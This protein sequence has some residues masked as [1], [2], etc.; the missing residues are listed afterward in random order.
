MKTGFITLGC[1]CLIVSVSSGKTL[2]SGSITEDTTW[3][4]AGS[5]YEV[6]NASVAADVTLTIQPGAVVQFLDWTSLTIHGRILANG[7]AA[8][9]I[10]FT[11]LSGAT[12]GN[13]WGAIRLTNGDGGGG[14]LASAFSHC[15]FEGGG[16]WF[17]TLL[18][19]WGGAQVSVSDCAFRHSNAD[20]IRFFEDAGGPIE[21]T[22]FED[23]DGY[24]LW[25]RGSSPLVHGCRFTRN[26]NIS[27]LESG[28]GKGSFPN[29]TQPTF[30]DSGYVHI[31][32]NID[33]SGTLTAAPYFVDGHRYALEGQTITIDG[34]AS[35]AMADWASWTIHGNLIANGT[36]AAPIRF[37]RAG[38]NEWGAI[39]LSNND[40]NGDGLASHLTHCHFEGGGYWFQT[41]LQV[42]GGSPATLDHCQFHHSTLDGLRFF[43]NSGTTITNSLFEDNGRYGLWLRGSSPDVQGSTFTGNAY[44]SRLESGAGSG[45][46]PQFADTH[47]DDGQRVH[48]ASNFDSGGTL[49]AAP[50]FLD[51]HRYALEDQTITIDAGASFA[52]ADWASWTIHGNLIANGTEAAPIRFYRAGD[53]EWGA[54]ILSN[55]D[56]NGERRASH[57]THCHFDGGGYWFQTLLQVHGEAPATIEDCQFRNSTLDGLR[58]FEN[59]GGPIKRSTFSDN[60]SHGLWL[61]GS[62]PLV[63]ACQFTGNG[64]A[65]RLESGAGKSSLPIFVSSTFAPGQRVH[66]ATNMPTSGTFT[67]APYFLDGHRVCESTESVTIDAGATFAMAAWSTW[68]I[69]G[70][71][72]AEGT[73]EAPITFSRAGENEW[74]AVRLTNH[75][76]NGPGL[77]NRLTYCQFSG[78][79]YWYQTLL[80]A[81]G[82]APITLDHCHFN[83]ST[84]DLARLSNAPESRLDHC[85]FENAAHYGLRLQSASPAIANSTFQSCGH[86]GILLL[87]SADHGASLPTFSNNVFGEDDYIEIGNN[88]DSSG[89]LA[90]PGQAYLVNGTRT[91]V[92]GADLS[93]APGTTIKFT[94]WHSLVVDGSL[95]ALGTTQRP[96]TFTSDDEEKEGH[97]WGAVVLTGNRT[98]PSAFKHCLLEAGGYWYNA[99]LDLSGSSPVTV[100]QCQLAISSGA[101]I[102]T[103]GGNVDIMLSSISAC[104]SHGIQVDGSAPRI[105]ACDLFENAQDGIHTNN[106]NATV[107]DCFLRDNARAGVWAASGTPPRVTNAF[108]SGNGEWGI[109]NRGNSELM[110]INN[111]WGDATGPQ[112]ATLNPEGKGD[113][114]SDHVVFQ[115]YRVFASGLPQELEAVLHNGE[116]VAGSFPRGVNGFYYAVDVPA[117]QNLTLSLD[118]ANDEGVTQ[119]YMSRGRYPTPGH[120]Q[121]RHE[122]NA[123]DQRLFA[124][125]A[126]PGR[127]YVLVYQFTGE[128]SSAY[129]IRADLADIAIQ[130]ISPE[131]HSNRVGFTMQIDGAGFTAGTHVALVDG[132]RHVNALSVDVDAFTRVTAT[133][134]SAILSGRY[135]VE[136]SVPGKTPALLPDAFE[137]IDGGHPKLVTDLIVPAAVGYHQL[138][139]LYVEYANEGDVAMP[140]PLLIVTGFQNDQRRALLTLEKTRLVTGFWTS[141]IPEGFA[142][143][144]QILGSGETPGILQPGES[145]RIPVY[146]AGWQKPWDFSYPPIEFGLSTLEAT[147][148]RAIDWPTLKASLNMGVMEPAAFEIIWQ[149]YQAGIG[150]T[151]GEFVTMLGQNAAYLSRLGHQIQD[152]S[153]L[154][155]FEFLQAEGMA[156]LPFLDREVDYRL[157]GAG[158]PLVFERLFPANLS[159]RFRQGDFG[160]GWWHSWD[161]RSRTLE[162]GTV[163]IAFQGQHRVFQPD[164]RGGF[165]AAPHDSGRLLS[166][167]ADID[168]RLVEADGKTYHFSNGQFS[169]VEDRHGNRITA[170][171]TG[172]RLSKLQHSSGASL[173]LSYDGS[174]RL[175]AITDHHQRRTSYAYTGEMLSQVTHANGKQSNY[176]YANSQAGAKAYALTAIQRSDKSGRNYN[177]D[178]NGRVASTSREGG[179][180]AVAITYDGHGSAHLTDALGSTT[181]VHFDHHGLATKTTDGHGASRIQRMSDDLQFEAE[182]DGLGAMRSYAYDSSGRLTSVTG[183]LGGERT[184]TYDRE[185]R[186]TAF[187]DEEGR[188]TSAAYDAQGNLIGVTYADG[189]SHAY[190]YDAQGNLS[191]FV[192]GRGERVTLTHDQAGRLTSKTYPDGTSA[193]YEYDARGRLSATDGTAGRTEYAYNAQDLPTRVTYPQGTSLTYQYDA[194]GRRTSMTNQRGEVTRYAYDEAGRIARLSDENG[195]TLVAYDYNAAGKIAQQTLPDGSAVAYDYHASGQVSE[196]RRYNASGTL[197][198]QGTITYDANSH[199]AVIETSQG[200]RRFEW[201]AHGQVL[202]QSF[203]PTGGATQT[204][205]YDYDASGRLSQTSVDGTAQP[206]STDARGNYLSAGNMTYEHD[207]DGNVTKVTTPSGSIDYTYDSENRLTNASGPDFIWTRTIDP[208]GLTTAIEEDAQTYGV[209]ND[210]SSPVT[211]TGLLTEAGETTTNAL[212]G[213]GFLSFQDP[214]SNSPLTQPNLISNW[215]HDSFPLTPLGLPLVLHVDDV[216]ALADQALRH[217][218]THQAFHNPVTDVLTHS[219]TGLGVGGTGLGM[220]FYEIAKGTDYVS[221]L[222]WFG[223]ANTALTGLSYLAGTIET[224]QGYQENDGYKMSHGIG[225]IGATALGG[226][227]TSAGGVAILGTAALPVSVGLGAAVLILDYG[228]RDGGWM[229]DFW[230]WWDDLDVKGDRIKTK[231][232]QSKDPNEKYGPAGQGDA[233]Y[234]SPSKTLSY[235]VD[236]EN[237]HDARAPAQVVMISDPLSDKLDWNSFELTEA[238]FGDHVI[239]VPG[240]S[241]SLQWVEPMTY[242]G[243]DLEV[244]ID[245]N[246]DPLTG[247]ITAIFSSTDAET[248]LPPEVQYGFLPP[249]DETGRGQGYFSYLIHAKADLPTGTEIRN[250]ATITFDFGEVIDTNQVDPHDP[251]QG[252]DPEKEAL[253]TIDG[254]APSS[255]VAS[256]PSTSSE[257]F[258]VSWSGTDVGAGVGSY[259]IYVRQG[260]GAF[261]PWLVNTQESS[262]P[263]TGINGRTYSFYAIARD[264]VGNEEAL[265]ASSEATTTID[266]GGGDAY[267]DWLSAHFTPAEIN[268][269]VIT[270]RLADPDSDGRTNLEEFAFA[271]DPRAN[272]VAEFPISRLGAHTVF[273]YWRQRAGVTY[274]VETS[275]NLQDWALTTPDAEEVLETEGTRERVRVIMPFQP[276]RSRYLRVLADG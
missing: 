203:T 224:V 46:F 18:E 118:D 43:E 134:P 234:V 87:S 4:A 213:N 273:E 266:G 258:L 276:D 212:F 36:E 208:T 217:P 74:G 193:S 140:A 116:A 124:P 157:Q 257:T 178:S 222:K 162:D 6:N 16:Y 129:T 91:I 125:T 275:A 105:D 182:E 127:W 35:F 147:D 28:G 49:T 228:A 66:I 21:A 233:H 230:I 180:E 155:Q 142:N 93:I 44:A 133:F 274:H 117:G 97:Q 263:F 245:I 167:G 200:R 61:R 141:A 138:A 113:L 67:A 34:G 184:F 175:T 188:Q 81:Y 255:T 14:Q 121:I 47:F 198:E 19:V 221:D 163:V 259:S 246:L 220:G 173:T 145:G 231:P 95:Q 216:S 159:R 45:S 62:S 239:P 52:M 78:G 120:Y 112:H 30:T 2:V 148:T 264:L 265:K 262:A 256:L 25:L 89:T 247:I 242:D 40:G 269:G 170:T 17:Q 223:R 201:N 185:N 24:G 10:R 253:V 244:A 164:A 196:E 108:I 88:I 37:H 90:D 79:G 77:A 33:S 229:E 268:A 165:F 76:G 136:I 20:A 161:M 86:N 51:S 55:S 128:T 225:S 238:G 131:R 100:D 158:M 99:L 53:N 181:E 115:P 143:T 26:G 126:G 240:S 107:T 191:A 122:A 106:G 260:T 110:A 209:M 149:N 130:S 250:V 195:G 176:H 235:R 206:V 109:N 204:M 119:V 84:L 29:F 271:T 96:I 50:Y 186:L 168:H 69:H 183:K 59:S 63:E 65:G 194:S 38:D 189:T 202:S 1:A 139:T 48:I 41:L 94:D 205:T 272:D 210:P 57:L 82:G 70:N 171:H 192:N 22:V 13:P 9:G 154:N 172:N 15:T 137:A 237:D 27:R 214:F 249:E 177:Y 156:P 166:G 152:V 72:I 261:E 232:S 251:S 31:A 179:H 150:S 8:Q 146:Y 92:A 111:W 80:E 243:K 32:T 104:G 75:E 5:P 23:N 56:G 60:A 64:Y 54:V 190:E 135:T 7:T 144:V 215:E 207:A 98:R 151:V 199:P 83:T 103:S 12:E 169:Y 68:T 85:H 187:T 252:T 227:M 270:T 248:G 132:V 153:A 218:L 114:V 241:Q 197:V 101:G 73:E 39:I 219:Y 236:F 267:P 102:R 3:S 254:D 58:F 226:W 174:G 71:L 123:A 211:F 160:R 11:S 42:H